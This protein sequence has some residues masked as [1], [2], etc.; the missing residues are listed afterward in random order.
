M[1]FLTKDALRAALAALHER[2]VDVPLLGGTVLLREF[3]ARD[4]ILA[5]EA[6]QEHDPEQPDN[7]LYRALLLQRCIVDPE[8]GR[9]YADG[10]LDPATGQPAIDPR[11]RAPLLSVEDVQTLAETRNVVFAFLWES[12]LELSALSAPALKSGDPAADAAERDAGA[13][14]DAAGDTLDGDAHSGPGDDDGR[15]APAD[16]AGAGDGDDQG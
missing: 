9:A 11:S 15:A 16:D 12:L 7:H 6:A 1:A 8:T 10:R 13:G 5:S 2:E 3:T 14:A 4:R